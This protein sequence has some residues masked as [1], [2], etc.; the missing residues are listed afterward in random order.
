[1]SALQ[2]QIGFVTN[3]VTTDINQLREEVEIIR[4]MAQRLGED[5][6]KHLSDFCFSVEVAYQNFHGLDEYCFDIVHK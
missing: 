6:P 2:F 1:M 5:L 4:D 3:V